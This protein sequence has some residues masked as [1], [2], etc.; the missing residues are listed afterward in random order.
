MQ[1]EDT[2]QVE[3]VTN[4]QTNLE[5]IQSQ[6]K[7]ILKTDEESDDV[8]QSEESSED[9][10]EEDE[11]LL[12]EMENELNRNS[13][14]EEEHVEENVE[15]N[16]DD[17]ENEDEED[18]EDEDEQNEDA[19][20]EDE[21]PALQSNKRKRRRRIN[22]SIL[23]SIKREQNSV[24]LCCPK[25]AFNR[26]IR[27]ITAEFKCDA[28]FD[29]EALEMLQHISEDLLIQIFQNTN[30]IAAYNSRDGITVEDMSLALALND[31]SKYIFQSIVNAKKP[32]W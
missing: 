19:A 27:E 18:V 12:Q 4:L 20:D 15:E 28:R 14:E 1:N 29:L 16:E 17:E 26:L 24:S 30:Q 7:E 21:T 25:E 32:T 3:I 2:D 22:P 31:N 13:E 6:Q 9:S 8:E 23:S 5:T 10:E 11:K